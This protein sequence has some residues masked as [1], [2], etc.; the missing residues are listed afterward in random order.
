MSPLPRWLY[1][2]ILIKDTWVET[3]WT[4]TDWPISPSWVKVFISGYGQWMFPKVWQKLIGFDSTTPIYLVGNAL[5]PH[6][7]HVCNGVFWP[8]CSL[9]LFFG[10]Q[11]QLSFKPSSQCPGRCFQGPEKKSAQPKDQWRVVF[12]KEKMKHEDRGWKKRNE[13]RKVLKN[14]EVSIFNLVFLEWCM[15]FLPH[16]ASCK[17][18]RIPNCNRNYLRQFRSWKI[19]LD[20]SNQGSLHQTTQFHGWLFD[21][22]CTKKKCVALGIPTPSVLGSGKPTDSPTWNTAIWELP[23]S[24]FHHSS[25]LAV[26]SF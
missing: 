11:Q 22:T 21:F 16:A 14:D 13:S 5:D 7:P 24:N 1:P 15:S 23:Q 17:H 2:N 10:S 3:C 12:R 26:R 19:V 18:V 25:D 8:S 9:D 20:G 6:G 4:P